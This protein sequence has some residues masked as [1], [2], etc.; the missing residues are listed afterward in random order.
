MSLIINDTSYAGTFASYF[1]LPATFGMDTIQKGAVYVKDGIKKKHTIGRIDLSN[2]LQPRAA[3]PTSNAQNGKFTIDGRSLEPKDHM[4]YTE[5]NPRDFEE[6]WLAEQ[7]SPTLLARELPVT[8]ENYMMQIALNRTFEVVETEIWMGSTTYDATPGDAGNGQLMFMDGFMKKFLNDSNVKFAQS[9][10]TLTANNVLSAMTGLINLVAQ[11]KKALISKASQWQRMKFFVSVNTAVL[12]QDALVV[13]TTF[14]GLN[15]MDQG[16][17]P[18]K[19]YEVV[20]LAG[21]PDNTI[22]FCE[23]L[24]DTSSN[25]YVGMNSTEDN[26][27]QLMRLQNNSELFFLKGLMKYDVQYGFSDQIFLYTTYTADYFNS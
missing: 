23:G 27:L 6:H 2:P 25:L 8:A 7:L 14:K 22:L 15:T 26:N 20:P 11:E 21:F 12:Y 16:I 5:F 1:W 18:W 17:K 9:P 3:T 19:G 4:F 10:Q 13:G 24:P